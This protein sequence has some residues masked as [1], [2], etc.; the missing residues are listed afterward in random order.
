M[1]DIHLAGLILSIVLCFVACLLYLFVYSMVQ[2]R[3]RK[4]VTSKE[5]EIRSELKN[6]GLF[7]IDEMIKRPSYDLSGFYISNSSYQKE[8]EKR[9]ITLTPCQFQK[10]IFDMYDTPYNEVLEPLYKEYE[11][12]QNSLMEERNSKLFSNNKKTKLVRFKRPEEEE[13]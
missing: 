3:A 13:K 2:N 10:C 8:N 11:N 5:E 7:Y 6:I 9:T 1:D 12:H 4:W